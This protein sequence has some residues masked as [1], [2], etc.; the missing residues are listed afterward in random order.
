MSGKHLAHTANQGGKVDALS[1][2]LE[3]VGRRAAEYASAFG[4]SVEAR[5]AGM[6]HDIGKYGILFRRR[7]EG[8]ESGIDHWTAGAWIALMN[9]RQAGIAS[10]LAIQGHH[11]GLQ[12]ASKDAL[13]LLDPKRLEATHPLGLRLSEQ[14]PE[15]LLQIFRDDGLSLP[16]FQEIGP[17]LYSDL[18]RPPVAGMLDVRMLF[19]CL[20]D[21]DFIETEAHF[22][23]NTDGSKRYRDSGPDLE[24]QQAWQALTEYLERLESLSNAAS[25]VNEL[26]ADLLTAC[27]EAGRQPPGLYTLTAPTGA[28]KT[29]S[30]L[31]FA[32]RHAL[33]HGLRRI[34]VVIPYLTIIEQTVQ[35]YRTIF[36]AFKQGEM[37]QE[38]VLEN[39]SLAGTRDTRSDGEKAVADVD[40]DLSR[41]SLFLAENWD[42]PI[43]ITTSVQFLESLFANRPSACRKLHRLAKSVILFDEVQTLGVDLAVPTLAALSRLVE[44]YESTVVFST[45]TQPAF[46]HL[47][48]SV[49]GYAAG[50]WN[51]REIVPP[52]LRLFER[53]KRTTVQWPQDLNIRTSWEDLVR[54]IEAQK[55][56]LCIVNLKRHA[57]L[58]HRLLHDNEVT[59]LCHLSTNMCPAHRWKVLDRV[60]RLLAEGK[61]CRLVSTQCVEAGVDLDF[62]MVF[63]AWGPLEAIA[64]AAGRCNRNGKQEKGFV[65]VFLPE[66]EAYPGGAYRQASGVTR[67][68]LKA[69]VTHEADIHSPE[70]FYEYYRLLYDLMDPQN[71]NEEL[72]EAIKGQDFVEVARHYRLIRQDAI[73]VLIPYDRKSYGK[74]KKEVRGTGLT[75]KW[76]VK[77]RPY[78]IGIFRPRPDDPI[79]P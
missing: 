74:L 51:P 69:S 70:T 17:P 1:E 73:N 3:S 27:V 57:L 29:L 52:T 48:K 67:M 6:L 44:R 7:L 49:K 64:Q 15:V 61:P 18:Q 9:Y 19:S 10:A 75:R 5:L 31:A 43:I 24:P 60:K 33:Q 35:V 12:K 50:G 47:H 41:Q 40:E 37:L 13:R 11:V 36:A 16:S 32:L 63:R 39:H 76:V 45:A 78:S 25:H 62:P 77:A 21:A 59:G 66:E 79:R 8:T 14:K 58:I 34:V 54:R 72:I 38:Y 68:L 23:G 2:H 4:A 26:R 55:Q 28:G 65:W 30:M 42:A 46:S 22:Q 56:V 71:R 20:V 53:A